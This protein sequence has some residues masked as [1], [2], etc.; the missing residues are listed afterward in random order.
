MAATGEAAVPPGSCLQRPWARPH[1]WPTTG[2]S[3]AHPM[4]PPAGSHPAMATAPHLSTPFRP[5]LLPAP[6]LAPPLPATTCLP[7]QD[8]LPAL[9][10]R[11][12][13]PGLLEA[14]P[15]RSTFDR[16]DQLDHTTHPDGNP[17]CPARRL[18]SFDQADGG[19]CHYECLSSWDRQAKSECLQTTCCTAQE[20]PACGRETRCSMP[21]VTEPG[22]TQ[23]C[24][25][26]LPLALLAETGAGLL[27]SMEKCYHATFYL[28]RISQASRTTRSCSP[29]KH[30]VA[31]SA[32]LCLRHVQPLQLFL[33]R[34]CPSLLRAVNL[35]R[36]APSPQLF[37]SK[38]RQAD[39]K[40]HVAIQVLSCRHTSA[41]GSRPG[42]C[43][44]GNMVA[45]SREAVR[46][47]DG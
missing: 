16:C 32:D 3:P 17:H 35:Q 46:A 26:V 9:Q 6:A 5:P 25:M 21:L 24:G 43:P 19:Y 27:P 13:P 7:R 23:V 22:L 4:P 37:C 29:C 33:C 11:S 41:Q 34:H 44:C 14:G 20:C 38:A 42:R 2:A 10:L 45:S 39:N 30:T 28:C 47:D 36:L 18:F 31:G 12:R 1:R 15:S 8:L 40:G